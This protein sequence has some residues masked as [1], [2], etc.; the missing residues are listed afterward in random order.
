MALPLLLA[1][2]TGCIPR[3]DG[4]GFPQL[5]PLGFRTR[6]KLGWTDARL[7]PNTLYACGSSHQER[8]DGSKKDPYNWFHTRLELE[9]RSRH[10][11]CE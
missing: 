1:G 5:R 8:F 3:V 9:P 11:G 6:E 2:L 4:Q 10:A 7:A